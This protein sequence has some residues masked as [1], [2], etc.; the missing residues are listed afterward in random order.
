MSVF[1]GGGSGVWCVGGGV[2][3][4]FL[5]ALFALNAR[6]ISCFLVRVAGAGAVGVVG[7]GVGVVVIAGVG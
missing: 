6:C 7:V 2:L 3:L 4:R 5:F 1:V